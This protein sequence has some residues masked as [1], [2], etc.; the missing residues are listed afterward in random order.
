VIPVSHKVQKLALTD[1]LTAME[2]QVPVAG[3]TRA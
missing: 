2:T 3:V 1:L